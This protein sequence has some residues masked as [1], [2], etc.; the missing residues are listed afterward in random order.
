M[1]IGRFVIVISLFG[2]CLLY[3]ISCIVEPPYVPL[4]AIASQSHNHSHNYENELIKTRGVVVDL[5]NL[6]DRNMLLNIMDNGTELPVF[7]SSSFSS[8]DKDSEKLMLKYGDVIELQGR[9][10]QYRGKYEIAASEGG[11]KKINSDNNDKGAYFVAEIAEY[12]SNYEGRRIRVVGY[13]C[14]VYKRIFYLCS[15]EGEST[16]YR[17]RVVPKRLAELELELEKGDK[18][19]IEGVLVYNPRDMRY[20]LEL[21]SLSC[22]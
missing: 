8:S 21:I 14:K 9:V 20:E 6:S 22:L 15:E 1:E 19:I 7:V 4:D 16:G 2:I 13:I 3:C 10:Q 17:M 11:L 5:M 18:V 12:P